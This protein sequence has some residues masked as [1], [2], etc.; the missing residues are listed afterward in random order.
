MVDK[1]QLLSLNVNGLRDVDKRRKIFAYL[2]DFKGDLIFLQETHASQDIQQIWQNEWGGQII[3]SNGSTNSRGVMTLVKRSSPLKIIRTDMDISGRFLI[4]EIEI[5]EQEYLFVNMYAPNEDD[6][7]FFIDLITQIELFD[8]RNIV[9]CGDFNLTFNPILDRFNSLHNNDKAMSAVSSYMLE[10]ELIDI[11]RH[12]NPTKIQFTWHG[13]KNQKSRIDMFL[14]NEGM[15]SNVENVMMSVNTLSDHALLSMSLSLT[16]QERGPGL[17]KFNT[18]HL[19]NML[20]IKDIKVEIQNAVA[21]AVDLAPD[22]TWEFI[23]MTIISFAKQRSK[24]SPK[25][26]NKSSLGCTAS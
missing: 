17:W 21:S 11:W 8:N 19:A 14:I 20:F 25:I 22:T 3:F 26:I 7:K 12:L 18:L 13:R 10:A 1:L 6:P 23:K 4:T 16:K 2:R 15:L 24:E 5:D 9:W